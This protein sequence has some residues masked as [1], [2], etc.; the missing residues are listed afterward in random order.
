MGDTAIDDDRIEVIVTRILNGK[1]EHYRHVS[2]CLE[3]RVN[4]D[5]KLK[6]AL[7]V[8]IDMQKFVEHMNSKFNKL[9][10]LLI[11]TLTALIVNLARH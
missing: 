4:V 7:E 10:M 2:P 6:E 5:E 8:K 3:R 9:Y 1:L 11:A